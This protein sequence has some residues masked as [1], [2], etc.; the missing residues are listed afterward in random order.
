MPQRIRPATALAMVLAG[1]WGL[2][3]YAEK[4]NLPTAADGARP[5]VRKRLTDAYATSQKVKSPEDC[6]PILETCEEA[7]AGELTP[8][9]KDYAHKLAAWA[10]NRRGELY[11]EQAAALSAQGKA[12]KAN[13][14]DTLALADFETAIEHDSGR[15]KALH[16]RGV[17]L[18]L[19]GK[20]DEALADFARVIEIKPDHAHAWFN[21][22]EL[23]LERRE[24]EQAVTDYNEALKLKSDDAAALLGRGT[25]YLGMEESQKA[26]ADLDS[27]VRLDAKNANIRARRG[28]CRQHLRMWDQA[29]DDYRQAIKMAPESPVGYRGAAWLMAT[30]PEAKIRNANLAVRTAQKAV[31]LSG[32]GDIAALDALAAALADAGQFDA[33]IETLTKAIDL[34]PESSR[35]PLVVRLDTYR[36]GKPHRQ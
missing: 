30:C 16:N 10:Y 32:G 18:A 21:R 14:L 19:H 6:L 15:W 34:L 4:P 29:A 31:D 5:D 27:A 26:L 13:E 2:A 25:A 11:A 33:A 36:A 1:V 3:A 9:N 23:R 17:S 22:A 28:D 35:E 12:R 20:T 7:L 8:Q 24:F